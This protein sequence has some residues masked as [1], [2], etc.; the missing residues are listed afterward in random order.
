M[1]YILRCKSSQFLF[2]HH[3]MDYCFRECYTF[4]LQRQTNLAIAI[5]FS[6]FVENRCDLPTKGK[7]F[8]RLIHNSLLVVVAASSHM[9]V[10][11]KHLHI[12]PSRRGHWLFTV[13]ECCQIDA[14]VFF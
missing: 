3:V 4:S 8:I 10:G 13:F 11:Q 5:Y 14:W 1:S 9:K 6:V 12:S 2:L 7:I